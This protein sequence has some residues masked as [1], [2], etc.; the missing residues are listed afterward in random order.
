[1]ATNILH[2]G[3]DLCRRI[4]VMQT[5]G[6]VVLRS[7]VKILAIHAAFDRE[8]DYSAVVF[9]NDIAAV[10]EEAVHETRTLTEAPFVLF[11]NPTNACDDGEFDL[12]VP[13]L[14]PPDVWLQKLR[15]VIQASREIREHS[16]TL[17]KD[18]AAAVSSSRELRA[19]CAISRVPPFDPDVLW[20]GR[21]G[22]GLP[23][24]KPPEELRP[25]ELGEK[26]G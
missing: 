2:V 24:S 16:R 6:F 9:H 22:D 26:A 8:E 13:A 3:E 10:S 5:A 14:T 1:M 4:P 18:S 21:D 12:V 7:E 11:Q 23:E 20:R 17:R 25:D 19:R 15:E